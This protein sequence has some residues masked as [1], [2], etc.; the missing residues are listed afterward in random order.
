MDNYEIDKLPFGGDC[1]PPERIV[2]AATKYLHENVELSGGDVIIMG[3]RHGCD[4]HCDIFEDLLC[5]YPEIVNSKRVQGFI[6]SKG[7]FVDRQEAWK[8]AVEQKQV[9]RRVGGDTVRGGTL[10]SENIY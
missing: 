4:Y 10:Y 2:V 5:V 6:T 1:K 9:I 7:R 3:I 8:I